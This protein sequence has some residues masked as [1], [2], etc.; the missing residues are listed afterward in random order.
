MMAAIKKIALYLAWLVSIVA[1]LGSLYFSEIRGFTPCELCWYQRILMYP[2][3]AILGIATYRNDRS[4]KSFVLPLSI[5]GWCV[6][7]YHYLLQKVPAFAALETCTSGVPCSGSY[8]EWFGF[9][10]IPFLAFIAFSLITILM[11]L[12]KAHNR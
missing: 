5:I 2:L 1:T 7:L 4:V 3:A 8:V 12:T 6:S 9:I 10:T 11:L